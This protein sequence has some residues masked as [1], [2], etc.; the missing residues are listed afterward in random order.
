M[1]ID[2]NTTT[3]KKMRKIRIIVYS[4]MITSLSFVMCS[5]GFAFVKLDDAIGEELPKKSKANEKQ[6]NQGEQGFHRKT[7]LTDNTIFCRDP[8]SGYSANTP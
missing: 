4:F 8:L 7:S 3:V 5:N 2:I 1:I 6:G